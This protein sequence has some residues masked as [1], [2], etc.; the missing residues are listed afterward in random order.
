MT[1]LR[2]LPRDRFD[3]VWMFRATPPEGTDW[4]RPVQPTDRSDGRLAH[5]DGLNLSRAWMLAELAAALPG[6]DPRRPALDA[7]AAAHGAAGLA[8]LD[9]MTYA[10]S[11]W[12]PSFAVYW[13]TGRLRPR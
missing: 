10:G 12:L 11:H 3:H 13:L 9:D 6:G 2:H 7:L 4:L 8:A 1:L 5:L